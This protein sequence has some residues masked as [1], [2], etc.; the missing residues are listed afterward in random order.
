MTKT[1]E[2]GDVMRAPPETGAITKY[3][4]LEEPMMLGLLA[5]CS[6]AMVRRA[7][8]AERTIVHLA[9]Q[10]AT[11]APSGLDQARENQHGKVISV[12]EAAQI[13]SIDRNTL[14]DMLKRGEG[15]PARR[16]GTSYRLDASAVR[17]WLRNGDIARTRRAR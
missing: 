9:H 13:L 3:A 5:A 2:L 17:D 14:Y 16:C 10:L 6:E 4:V 15:P 11:R 12:V 1:D 7:D 8:E